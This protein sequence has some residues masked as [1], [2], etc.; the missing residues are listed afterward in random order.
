MDV[1][2]SIFLFLYIPRFRIDQAFKIN[3][4]FLPTELPSLRGLHDFAVAGEPES[5]LDDGP[6]LTTVN[7]AEYFPTASLKCVPQRDV[8][9]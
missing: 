1:I 7:Q 5:L 2:Y 9:L 4:D 3:N 8:S 6:Q